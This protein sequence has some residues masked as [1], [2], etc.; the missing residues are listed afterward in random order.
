[1]LG[2]VGSISKIRK[3]LVELASRQIFTLLYEPEYKFL[4]IKGHRDNP[5]YV[6]V[7]KK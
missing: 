2:G 4:E 3:M 5:A 7:V 1:M 6:S